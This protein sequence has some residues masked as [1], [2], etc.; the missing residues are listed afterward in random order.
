MAVELAIGDKV[1][2]LK[3]ND[4]PLVF[5]G[6]VEKIY[7]NSALLTIDTFDK[8]D[9]ITV[10]DLKHRTVINFKHIR[11]DGQEV[12][13]PKIEEDDKKNDKKKPGK[14]VE[15]RDNKVVTTTIDPKDDKDA[16]AAKDDKSDD[17]KK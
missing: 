2:V 9:N 4:V 13:A 16:K 8:E 14:K 17:A 11:L 3:S 7:T 15:V 10:E 6:T 1:D 5:S 12:M